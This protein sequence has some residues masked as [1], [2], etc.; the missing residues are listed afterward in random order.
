MNNIRK[1]Q[2]LIKLAEE[3]SWWGKTGDWFS[4]TGSNISE[5]WKNVNPFGNRQ[6]KVRDSNDRITQMPMSNLESRRGLKPL[7]V[8][9]LRANVA[10]KKARLRLK[11]KKEQ[12]QVPIVDPISGRI[13]SHRERELEKSL[14]PSARGPSWKDTHQPK[15]RPGAKEGPKLRTSTDKAYW[16]GAPAHEG[17]I[18]KDLYPAY[19]GWGE[20]G[21]SSSKAPAP[22]KSLTPA[23]PK[24]ATNPATAFTHGKGQGYWHLA[25]QVNKQYGF[26]A[27]GSTRKGVT[28][29]ELRGLMSGQ[30]LHAGSKK[31]PKQ[32]SFSKSQFLGTPTKGSLVGAGGLEGKRLQRAI[33]G[34]AKFR[35]DRKRLAALPRKAAVPTVV[36]KPAVKPKESWRERYSRR[37]PRDKALRLMQRRSVSSRRTP[38]E[39]AEANRLIQVIKRRPVAAV[40]GKR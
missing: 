33:R 11:R 17:T 1:Q 15:N 38:A 3:K 18:G 32:Y 30:M 12:V 34:G 20:K 16:K 2:I 40:A 7:N 27:K 13:F 36:A 23:V 8:A 24:P 21:P 14:L 39:K 25:R 6:S 31:K 19:R 37:A 4:R 10:A 9:Q 5:G 28:S 26:G 35:A 29:R 22:S